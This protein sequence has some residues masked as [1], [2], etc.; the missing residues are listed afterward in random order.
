M[1]SPVPSIIFFHQEL[2]KHFRF[3]TDEFGFVRVH[4]HQI[5]PRAMFQN[6]DLDL[7]IGHENGMY[8]AIFWLKKNV[9]WL[10]PYESKLFRVDD[11]VR[12]LGEEEFRRIQGDRSVGGMTAEQ[13]CLAMFGYFTMVLKRQCE[14]ILRGDYQTLQQLHTR[15]K[16]VVQ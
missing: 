1:P 13:E 10:L 2:E 12:L 7:W 5:E 9:P 4:D 8:D 3:L 16:T 15:R 14:S 11:I 6:D